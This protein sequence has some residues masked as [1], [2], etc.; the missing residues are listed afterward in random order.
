M[1][2]KTIIRQAIVLIAISTISIVSGC[3]KDRTSDVTSPDT[4]SL[5]Q[6]A[7]DDGQVQASDNEITNDVNS[8]LTAHSSK[9]IDS[10]AIN[11]CTI[12]VDTIAGGDSLQIT[13]VYNGFNTGH[14]FT[15]TGTV[16][17][18]KPIGKHW[19]DAGCIVSFQYINLAITK[20][21][22]GKK[23]TFN[24][25]RQFENYSGGRIIDLGSTTIPTQTVEH[26]ITGAMQITFENGTT[27]IW[28]ISRT[29]TWT[30][31]F[32]SALVLTIGSTG[33][34]SGVYTNLVEYGTN[35]NGE[36]FYTSIN[37]PIEYSESCYW[38]P[39][40]G[41]FTHQI[42][43]KSKSATVTFGYNSSDQLVIQGTC[44][45]FYR[46]DWTVNGVP[47]T[48]YLPL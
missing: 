38:D 16:I 8:A 21:S 12:T 28:N 24:G 42:P 18:T 46:L 13:M 19:S 45:D 25:N 7:Q 20:V 36:A 4:S 39:I 47:G 3:K 15:R 35:R 31:T 41:S 30:G 6:L 1:K 26:R 37:T 9:A 17:I 22:S 48:I 11:A 27:R 32:P 14:N 34:S 10:T 23:F 40:W 2:T 33:A 5:Q 43:G 29:R 44:A